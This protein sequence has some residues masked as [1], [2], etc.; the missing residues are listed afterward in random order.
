MGPLPANLFTVGMY[1]HYCYYYF[2]KGFGITEPRAKGRSPN[3]MPTEKSEQWP[4]KDGGRDGGCLVECCHVGTG[5]QLPGF[6][7]QEKPE[8]QIF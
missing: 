1:V 5:T 6:Q 3:Q 2:K 8:I 7:M 4:G